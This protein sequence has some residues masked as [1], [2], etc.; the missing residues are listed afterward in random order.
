MPD[1]YDAVI[2]A[3]GLGGL[4]TP[5]LLAQPGNRV[6]VIDRHNNP[7]GYATNFRRKGFT[8]DVSLHS[9]DG[10]MPG[11]NS[12]KCIEACGVADKIEFLAH[13]KLYR[14]V[15]GDIDL[16]VGERD[17]ER[18]KAQLSALFPG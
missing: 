15:S 17:V 10:V 2:V 7:G 8:F 12:Y 18:Y 6:L 4:A 1:A 3:A 16:T 13:K 14:L 11:A 5:R 9:F